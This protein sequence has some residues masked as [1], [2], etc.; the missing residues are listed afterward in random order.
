MK[1]FLLSLIGLALLEMLMIAFM[2]SERMKRL[3]HLV[4]GAAMTVL[5]LS[6]LPGFDYRSYAAAISRNASSHGW[7]SETARETADQ[8]NRRIIESEFRAYIME[9]AQALDV[10]LSDAAVELTWSTEGYWYPT[11]AALTGS[12]KS[13]GSE[14]LNDILTDELGIDPEN[15]VWME[16][17]SG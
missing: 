3:T 14:A 8:L 7:S 17:G 16:E 13:P 5:I 1:H 10:P 12:S 11:G 6:T 15:I 9:Q 4:C 2:G